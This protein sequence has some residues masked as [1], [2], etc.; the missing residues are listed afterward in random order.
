VVN[1]AARVP[2]VTTLLQAQP[3]TAGLMP[4]VPNYFVNITP[5]LKAKMRAI[6]KHE[7]Q[8]NYHSYMAE[9]FHQNRGS[10]NAFSAGRDCFAD[11]ELYEAFLASLIIKS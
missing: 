7:T 11:G 1:A 9:N 8:L 10:I 4:F 5:Y 2:S 6:S 3:L